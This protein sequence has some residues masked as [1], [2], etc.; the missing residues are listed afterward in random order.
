MLVAL[1]GFMGSGKSTLMNRLKGAEGWT[2]LD[3]DQEILKRANY[4]SVSEMVAHRGWDFFRRVELETFESLL[5]TYV[6]EGGESY[7]E[8]CLLALGGGTLRGDTGQIIKR[9]QSQGPGL[10]IVYLDTPFAICWERISGDSS[11]PLVKEGRDTVEQL[12]LE[13]ESFYRLFA[14]LSLNLEQQDKILH[15]RDLVQ[16]DLSD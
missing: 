2:F 12:Y 15:P 4:E 7:S 10:T 8:R 13:R 5:E 14:N 11:R 9:V 1:T 3:L 16:E 6:L